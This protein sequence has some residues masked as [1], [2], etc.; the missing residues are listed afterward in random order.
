MSWC[1]PNQSS[2]PKKKRAATLWS[3]K[4]M[5]VLQW[6]KCAIWCRRMCSELSFA[7]H[8]KRS[9]NKKWEWTT[10]VGFL[11]SWVALRIEEG[12]SYTGLCYP[13]SHM[14]SLSG[15]MWKGFRNISVYYDQQLN[16]RTRINESTGTSSSEKMKFD[17]IGGVIVGIS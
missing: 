7:K 16:G 14:E 13:K 8:T 1:Y 12:K 4:K 2:Y 3:R 9:P 6:E 5:Y 10:S 11:A 17:K 15:L